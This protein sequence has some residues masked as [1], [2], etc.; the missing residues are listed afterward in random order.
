MVFM[1]M[2]GSSQSQPQNLFPQVR[3]LSSHSSSL[4]SQNPQDWMFCVSRASATIV[5]WLPH[6]ELV[7]QPVP[8]VFCYYF[9]ILGMPQLIEST[10]S[11]NH[12]PHPWALCLH[13]YPGSPLGCFLENHKPLK[14]AHEASKL[15]HYCNQIWPPNP[16]DHNSKWLLNGT[17]DRIVLR[18]HYIYCQ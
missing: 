13:P 7:S 3:F 17:F 14:L 6:D 2:A 4:F 18:D 8:Q 16:L 1:A 15:R 12:F 11:N 9:F 5:P 10:K